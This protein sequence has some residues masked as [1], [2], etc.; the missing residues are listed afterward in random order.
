ME[1][2]S[3]NYNAY[4]IRKY[5]NGYILNDGHGFIMTSEE[6][7]ELSKGLLNVALSCKEEIDEHNK[8]Q[9]LYYEELNK[10]VNNEKG[11]HDK[12]HIYLIECGGKYKIGLSRN[13]DRRLKELDYRP[14]E[15][16]LVAKSSLIENPFDLERKLHKYFESSRINGEWFNLNNEQ[17]EQVRVVLK[18]VSNYEMD[19]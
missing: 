9:E 10:R 4:I 6:M 19:D 16:K 5:E 18:K 7:I 17:V 8:E 13:V 14:F 12:A 1:F 3:W 2:N 11:K 15:I